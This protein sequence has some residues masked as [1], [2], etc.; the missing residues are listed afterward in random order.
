MEKGWRPE[1]KKIKMKL[2]DKQKIEDEDATIF[3]AKITEYF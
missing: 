1:K 3:S 2:K